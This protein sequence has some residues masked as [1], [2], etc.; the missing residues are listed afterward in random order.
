MYV[1]EINMPNTSWKKYL[2]S[3]F[4]LF[5]LFHILVAPKNL[6]S[7]KQKLANNTHYVQEEFFHKQLTKWSQVCQQIEGIFFEQSWQQKNKI[8]IKLFITTIS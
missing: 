4:E 5:G 1:K 2:M 7:Q 6:T 8:L 3:V